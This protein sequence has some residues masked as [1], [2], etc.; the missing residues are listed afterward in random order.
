MAGI[1]SNDRR[2]WG[3]KVE[4]ASAAQGDRSVRQASNRAWS[5]APCE[6]MLESYQDF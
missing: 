1:S 5:G 6:E 3:P 2:L 4:L